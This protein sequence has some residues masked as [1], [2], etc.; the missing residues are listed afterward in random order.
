MLTDA[1]LFHVHFSYLTCY[2]LHRSLDDLMIH[3]ALPTE[4][5]EEILFSYFICVLLSNLL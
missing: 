1:V 4:G 3:F 5:I 2:L